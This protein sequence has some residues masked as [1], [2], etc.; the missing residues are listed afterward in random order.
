MFNKNICNSYQELYNKA[1]ENNFK[2]YGDL[3]KYNNKFEI[4]FLPE[5]EFSC[6]LMYYDHG[7][8]SQILLLDNLPRLF[9][10]F[11]KWIINIDYINKVEIYK[12]KSISLFYEFVKMESYILAIY[13][14][15]IFVFNSECM[16]IWSSG[17]RDIIEK[18]EVIDGKTILITCS[19]GD[20]NEFE[21]KD[22]EI[23][24]NHTK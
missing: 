20:K 4:I 10:G 11:D 2:I 9:V 5:Y 14:L 15:D 23:L 12:Q 3:D 21:I 1:V 16:L 8:S 17:F 18:Y 13:E 7:I 22:G 19:N 6:G 24:N